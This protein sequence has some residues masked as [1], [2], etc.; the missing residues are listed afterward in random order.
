MRF[1]VFFIVHAGGR[2][3]P[4]REDVRGVG[5]PD[6]QEGRGG[7]AHGDDSTIRASPDDARTIVH[8]GSAIG[9]GAEDSPARTSP[10]NTD[11]GTC[12]AS[13]YNAS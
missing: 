3:Q 4:G 1:F 5:E 2:G 11:G 12:A 13:F 8:A 7:R 9:C 6:G 10:G